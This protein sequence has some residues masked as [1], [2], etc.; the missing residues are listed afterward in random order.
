MMAEPH[1]PARIL[2]V[3]DHRTNRLILGQMLHKKGYQVDD[4]TNGREALQKIEAG[5]YDMVLLDVVMPEMDGYQ[6]L[7]TLKK[8]PQL[9]FIPVIMISSVGEI[10]SVVKCISM[11]AEDYL[12]KPFNKVLLNAR[13]S[14]SLEKKWWRDKEQ[15]YLEQIDRERQ[16]ADELLHVI[17]PAGVVQELK[18]TNMVRPRRYED[19]AVLFCDIVS[20]TS[21]CDKNPP[22]KVVAHLQDL[23]KRFEQLAIRY[24]IQKI[25]TIGDAFMAVGGLLEKIENPVYNCVL[26]G[27]DMIK[28]TAEV[29]PHWRVRVGIHRGSVIAGIIGDQQYLFDV[30]GDTVNTAQ[31]VEHSAAENAVYVS[32]SAWETIKDMCPGTSAGLIELKGKGK[33][34]IF[35]VSF[36]ECS[37]PH[38]E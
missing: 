1:L 9:R 7:E 22:E 11:G 35:N 5:K 16:R 24:S 25:K 12:Q 36:Q 10:E 15:K 3:D 31:R 17:L 28:A 8:D 27:Q 19:V 30:W 32:K 18:A 37:G 33:I 14:A 4:A 23:V 38:Y 29:E 13:V 26:L 21:Y 20:F 2:V 6:V 34:E